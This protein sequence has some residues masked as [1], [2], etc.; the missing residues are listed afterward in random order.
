MA[1]K[2]NIIYEIWQDF[3]G[4]NEKF[5]DFNNAVTIFFKETSEFIKAIRAKVSEWKYFPA[6]YYLFYFF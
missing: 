3:Q 6:R 5:C 4:R 2:K 1:S